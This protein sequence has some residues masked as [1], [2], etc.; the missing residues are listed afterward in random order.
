MGIKQRG[1]KALQDVLFTAVLLIYLLLWFSVSIHSH[2]SLAAHSS[3]QLSVYPHILPARGLVTSTNRILEPGTPLKPLQ[4]FK[5][6]L[7]SSQ[8]SLQHTQ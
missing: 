8:S 2:I 7:C 1:R 5:P 6:L 3:R 4:F